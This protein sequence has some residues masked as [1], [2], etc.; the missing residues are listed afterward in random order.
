MKSMTLNATARTLLAGLLFVP[1]FARADDW[2][3]TCSFTSGPKLLLHYDAG[4]P[5]YR[6][7]LAGGVHTFENVAPDAWKNGDSV[8]AD[9]K[10]V[11]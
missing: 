1:G 8:S 10:S 7:T 4:G 6:V 3:L 2:T 9:R 11:V 5:V